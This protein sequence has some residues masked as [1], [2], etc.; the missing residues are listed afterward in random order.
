M[1]TTEQALSTTAV[2]DEEQD[3]SPSESLPKRDWIH[4]LVALAVIYGAVARIASAHHL[5]PHIDEPA[6]VLAAKMVSERGL[7]IFPSGVPYFQGGVLSYLLAPL[8][9]LGYGDLADLH[10]MRMVSVII[11][12]LTIGA[13]YL[14]ARQVSGQRWVGAVAALLVASD[15]TSIK[16]SGLVRMY[17]PLELFAVLFIWVFAL[18]MME[19]P[20][21]RRLIALPIVFWLGVF[22]HIATALLFPGV[23]IVALAIYGRSL[24]RERRDLG[25]SLAITAVAPFALTVLNSL[26]GKLYGAPA[27]AGGNIPGVSFVGDHLLTFDAVRSPSFASWE[28]LFS[29]S[30]LLHTTPYV[31]LLLSALVFGAIFLV[32]AEGEAEHRYRLGMGIILGAYWIPVIIVGVF[33]NEPQERYLIHIVPSGFVVVAVALQRIVERGLMVPH[34]KDVNWQRWAYIGGSL[35]LTGVLLVQQSSAALGLSRHPTLDPD[36]VAASEW[37]ADHREPGELVASAM[38]PAPY[39]VFDDNPDDLIFFSGN[40]YSERT[41]RYVRLDNGVEV[42]YWIGVESIY[43]LNDVCTTI[44]ENPDMFLI[45][46]DKRL[47][48]PLAF[49]GNL[50]AVVRGLMYIA[51]IGPGNVTVFRPSPLPSHQAG[52]ENICARAAELAEQGVTENTWPTP[53][54]S[55]R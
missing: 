19:G 51:Y 18:I 28:E 49:G 2:T 32:P 27:S 5:T 40:A 55:F 54:L 50:N 29:D 43:L 21:K 38:T 22:T 45:I 16:W 11:G 24:Y 6:S 30:T 42:D 9:W 41:K 12:V 47:N 35:F 3:D 37:V 53:D 23:A 52:A 31:M 7:P 14:L 20:T 1:L 8:M 44:A 15:P 33:T 26:L 13:A 25:L 34:T 10:T 48:N 4:V 36:Y 39:L 17:A 46:D